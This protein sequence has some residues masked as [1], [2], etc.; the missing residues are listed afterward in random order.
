MGN[1]SHS[2]QFSTSLGQTAPSARKSEPSPRPHTHS[3]PII[4]KHTEQVKKTMYGLIITCIELY[5]TRQNS[6]SH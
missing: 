2:T 3:D 6:M 5:D 1:F 4:S